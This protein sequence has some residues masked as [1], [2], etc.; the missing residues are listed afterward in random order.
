MRTLIALVLILMSPIKLIGQSD[1]KDEAT[2]RGVLSE[3]V[4]FKG[5]YTGW[6]EKRLGRL[7]DATSVE[8]T[9]IFAGKSLDH[10]DVEHILLII[11]LSYSFPQGILDASNREPRTTLFLLRSLETLA[12]DTKTLAE[13]T[14]TRDYV[15]SQY[16]KIAPP[17]S[18]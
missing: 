11:R 17:K 16:A 6:D 2:V 3:Q 18:P 13:I 7:G 9:K 15:Q 1:S 12:T 14:E 8:L 10:D 4:A 5:G